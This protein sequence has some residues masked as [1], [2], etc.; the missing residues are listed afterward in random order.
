MKTALLLLLTSTL[1]ATEPLE[2]KNGVRFKN[3]DIKTYC[4]NKD[5]KP[6]DCDTKKLLREDDR[7]EALEKRIEAL[8]KKDRNEKSKNR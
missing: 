5:L 4:W 8:E 2:V 7:I 3:A 6:I 1:W